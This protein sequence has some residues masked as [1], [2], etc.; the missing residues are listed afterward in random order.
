MVI[1]GNAALACAMAKIIAS[2]AARWR[3]EVPRC[4]IMLRVAMGAA[5]D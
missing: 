5:S 2:V 4:S 3:S 1:I